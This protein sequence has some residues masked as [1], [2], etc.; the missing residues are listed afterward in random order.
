M[1]E[2]SDGNDGDRLMLLALLLTAT[3]N[4]EAK[5]VMS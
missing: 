1:V 5:E 3:S 4:A 2:Q